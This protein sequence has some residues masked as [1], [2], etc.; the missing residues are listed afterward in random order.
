MTEYAQ[1]CQLS[2]STGSA[3]IFSQ[4]NF[5][6]NN[7]SPVPSVA[8]RAAL[9]SATIMPLRQL[10]QHLAATPQPREG[11]AHLAASLE[12]TIIGASRAV[13]LASRPLLLLPEVCSGTITMLQPLPT[14]PSA[15]GLEPIPTTIPHQEACSALLTTR[16][17]T[18]QAVSLAQPTTS[19]PRVVN[20]V[21]ATQTLRVNQVSNAGC[22]CGLEYDTYGL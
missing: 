5:G 19:L 22:L 7:P 12:Q 10:R 15:A 11:L 4:I 21:S 14:L 1:G 17:R 13:S 3:R 8:T 16:L 2:N 6:T 9:F 18:N 20:S